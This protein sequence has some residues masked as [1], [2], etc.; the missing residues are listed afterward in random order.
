M[1]QRSKREKAIARKTFNA[2]HEREYAKLIEEVRRKAD[3]IETADDLWAL[4]NFLTHARREVD[5]KYDYRYSQ[6][7]SVFAGLILDGLLTQSDLDGLGPD[8]MNGI[9]RVLE[10][11]RSP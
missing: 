8:K 1:D 7:T 2:A 9:R 4:H 10:F 11:H 6:L 5:E 3:A